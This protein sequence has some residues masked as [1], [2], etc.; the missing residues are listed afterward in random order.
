MGLL[1]LIGRVL[2]VAAIASS[3]YLHLNAP[4]RSIQEFQA[5]YSTLD[6]LSQQYLSYDLPLDQVPPS[7]RRPTGSWP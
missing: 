3:A 6:G 2:I 7:P 4:E 1:T 5:N